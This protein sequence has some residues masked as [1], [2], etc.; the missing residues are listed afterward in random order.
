MGMRA[1]MMITTLTTKRPTRPFQLRISRRHAS[2][3]NPRDRRTVNSPKL[4]DDVAEIEV[5]L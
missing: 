2:D 3:I 1:P 4:A 5:I